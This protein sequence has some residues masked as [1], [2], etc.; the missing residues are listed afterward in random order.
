[1]RKRINIA[2]PLLLVF[3]FVILE[4]SLFYFYKDMKPT[5]NFMYYTAGVLVLIYLLNILLIK[6]SPKADRY[7]N[8][9]VSMLFSIGT[10][11]I[12]RLDEI[13]GFKQVIWISIG[14]L[15]FYL[16]I[17][18]LTAMKNKFDKMF[19]LVLALIYIL[20]ILTLVLGKTKYGARNWIRLGPVRFQPGEFIKILYIFLQ[21]IY[22]KNYKRYANMKYGPEIFTLITYSFIMFFFLQKDLGSAVII[23]GMMMF[24]E[25]V[26]EKKKYL[27][28]VNLLLAVV[29]SVVS[30]YLFSH[31]R[32]RVL[33][34]I[35]PWDY[36]DGI[37]LQIT[38]SLF[39][40]SS[41][42]FLGTGIGL[43]LPKTIPVATSDFIFSAI[44]EEMGTLVGIAIIMLFIMLI[45]R[46]F[47]IALKS[48]DTFYKVLSFNCAVLFSVQALL[49][50]GGVLKLIPLTGVTLPFVAYGGTSILASF[51]ILAMVQLSSMEGEVDG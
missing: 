48:N 41:G 38:Q 14:I 32:V 10:F 23:Y 30:Y 31:V 2:R 47:K 7:L 17:F 39:A 37:G 36:M 24:S 3:M 51:I 15:V 40:I 34:F 44:C 46:I 22:Y 26:F 12:L 19:F 33:S 8:L 18:I 21:A 4:L 50:L 1:M 43:G 42:G 27:K 16:A 13:S 28:Y 45:S 6:I 25:F 9:I 20:F 29:M 11:E 49:I 35:N 5:N